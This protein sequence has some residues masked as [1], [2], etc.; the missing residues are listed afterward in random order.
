MVSHQYIDALLF[1][2][3]ILVLDHGKVIQQGS[4]LDVL[5][6]PQSPYIAEMVGVNLM[7][8]KGSF[9]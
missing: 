6:H 2:H 1:G 8:G 7:K 4:H 9:N 3:Q 5:L